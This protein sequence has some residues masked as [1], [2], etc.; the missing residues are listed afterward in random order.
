MWHQIGG[1]FQR[2]PE[3]ISRKTP[4]RY[5]HGSRIFLAIRRRLYTSVSRMV[6]LM[7]ILGISCFQSLLDI[8][9]GRFVKS[10]A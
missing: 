5:E 6:A 9:G 8:P 7:L 4:V 2:Y 1:L 10:F 3:A